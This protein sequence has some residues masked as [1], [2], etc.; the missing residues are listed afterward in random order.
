MNRPI[1]YVPTLLVI[2]AVLLMVRLGL[3]Q[4][5]RRHEKQALLARYAQN[6]AKPLLPFAALW[7]IGEDD[8]FRRTSVTCL[9]AAGWRA[10]AGRSITGV[11]G[12]RHIAGCRTGAEGP[13]VLVDL[14]VSASST[15]PGWPGGRVT[16]RLTWAP[17]GSPLIARL[18]AAP[19]PPTPLI[20]SDTASPG[21]S[22]S[23][24]PDPAAIPN[25]HLA[26]AIQWFIF[27]GLAAM[28]YGLLLLRRARRISTKVGQRSDQNR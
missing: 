24:Q 21:L 22:P 14:G 26:Y 23:A 19:P 17:D 9:D 4:L 10:E 12:W 5:D 18:F 8:L 7:P 3:W 16:G 25:N 6:Q 15:S 20:V 28:I 2:V 27:A 11:S 1:P 13:G